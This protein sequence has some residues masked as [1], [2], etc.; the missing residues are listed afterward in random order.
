[1]KNMLSFPAD[2][3]EGE[4]MKDD[5]LLQPTHPATSRIWTSAHAPAAHLQV[6]VLGISRT[7]TK[8]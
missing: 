7:E 2:P 8:V 5:G 1:M 6:C 4:T 3:S